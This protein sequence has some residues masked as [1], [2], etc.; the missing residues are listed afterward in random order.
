MSVGAT[1]SHRATPTSKATSGPLR[2]FSG[3]GKPSIAT[4]PENALQRQ[5]AQSARSGR[6]APAVCQGKTSRTSAEFFAGVGIAYHHQRARGLVSG[7]L[8]GL[9]PSGRVEARRSGVFRFSNLE[10][11]APWGATFLLPIAT[12][13]DTALDTSNSACSHF[14]LLC[15]PDGTKLK[16]GMSTVLDGHLLVHKKPNIQH[17][18]PNGVPPAYRVPYQRTP[19]KGGEYGTYVSGTMY[20]NVLVRKKYG[21][22]R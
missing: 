9:A 13:L 7:P 4:S 20:Q 11:P 19:P 3:V 21:T 2:R 12:W 1:T 16:S 5:L 18:T 10:C 8:W 15:S 14:V 17:P 6:C 22:V